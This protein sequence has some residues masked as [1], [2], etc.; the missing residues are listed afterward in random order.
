MKPKFLGHNLPKATVAIYEVYSPYYTLLTH[1]IAFALISS[2]LP[3]PNL[4]GP[5]TSFNAKRLTTPLPIVP[6]GG[7]DA[8]TFIENMHALN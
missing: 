5:H 8:Y 3:N 2:P 1:R 4:L 7:T 6:L